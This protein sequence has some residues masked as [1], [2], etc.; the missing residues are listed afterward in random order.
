M[1]NYEDITI[2]MFLHSS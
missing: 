2:R 1:Q